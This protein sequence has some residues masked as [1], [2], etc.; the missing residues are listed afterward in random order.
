ME[1]GAEAWFRR[2]TSHWRDWP[3][4][5]LM[6]WKRS[7]DTH[8]SVVI[9]ARNEQATVGGIVDAVAHAFMREHRL[10]DELAVM[11]SDSTDGTAEAAA[12]AGATVYWCRD[13]VPSLGAHPG[14]GE[15]LWKSLN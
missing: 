10:V 4:E 1:D 14:K 9:P 11:D 7:S 6:R 2:Q 3:L 15:A 8:I 12:R 13:V 5:R